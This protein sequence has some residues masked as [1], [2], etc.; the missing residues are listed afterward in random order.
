MEP[1]DVLMII[2]L[3]AATM[4]GAYKG[5]V[6]QIASLGA[7]IISYFVAM[8][9]RG[10]VAMRIGFDPP[11]DTY[12][13]M[14]GLYLVTSLVI[15]SICKYISAFLDRLK[16]REFDHQ[17]G[18]ILGLAKGVLLC[19]LITLFSVALS[20]DSWRKQIIGSF[21]GYYIAVLL[22]KAHPV[23]PGEVHDVLHRYLH[24]LDERLDDPPPIRGLGAEDRDA[25]IEGEGFR[26][27]LKK[28]LRIGE[29]DASEVHR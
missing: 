6:W 23:L 29:G 4:F 19:V 16:L 28:I 15:W 10:V 3:A 7:I 13:A 1:Y 21:S 11:W 22:D 27:E 18:A 8:R 26:D 5:L 14:L 17:I 9:F 25:P 20:S 24:S 12:V 2:V